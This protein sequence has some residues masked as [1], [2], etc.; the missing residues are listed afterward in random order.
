MHLA[1]DYVV[2]KML[3]RRLLNIEI[4]IKNESDFAVVKYA[5]SCIDK[6]IKI[7]LG[8]LAKIVE[9]S[10]VF[11]HYLDVQYR[12]PFKLSGS[13]L[14]D[15][16]YGEELQSCESVIFLNSTQ[17]VGILISLDY[18]HALKSC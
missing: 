9:N 13:S 6:C 18:R 4:L 1:V 17:K 7:V 3:G 14:G 12:I 15:S 8:L 2:D 16:N 10:C 5:R 11:L